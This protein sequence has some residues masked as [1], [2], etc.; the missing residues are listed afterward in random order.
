MQLFEF[1]ACEKEENSGVKFVQVVNM[2]KKSEVNSG[3]KHQ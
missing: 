1:E 3:I 2:E